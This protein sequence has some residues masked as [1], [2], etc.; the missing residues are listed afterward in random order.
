MLLVLSLSPL[1]VGGKYCGNIPFCVP[2]A[3]QT[4]P[5]ISLTVHQGKAHP[6]LLHHVTPALCPQVDG[7]PSL[8]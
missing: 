8:L 3:H 2:S 7:N 4:A 5:L 6:L 1:E